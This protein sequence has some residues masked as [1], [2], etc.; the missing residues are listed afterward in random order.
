M[1]IELLRDG[2]LFMTVDYVGPGSADDLVILPKSLVKDS[3]LSQE[4]FENLFH[5]C[6]KG[7]KTYSEAYE[8]AEAIHEQYFDKRRYASYESFSTVK[9][10]K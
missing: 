9:N 1:K 7:S 3:S 10:R 5:E 4:S 6:V 2:K 8:K